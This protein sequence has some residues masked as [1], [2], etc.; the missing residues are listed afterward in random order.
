MSMK[1]L[2]T[3]ALFIAIASAALAEGPIGT[4]GGPDVPFMGC[5]A[6]EHRDFGGA[7]FTFRGNV[8]VKY[9][10][11]RWNDKISSFACRGGCTMTFFEHRDFKGAH[12]SWGT[13]QYVGDDWN[14]SISSLYVRCE[15]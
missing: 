1:T 10:G 15:R 11:D 7:K 5:I 3:G 12:R 4:S 13:T 2:F 14:D 8:N 6:Y 9:I